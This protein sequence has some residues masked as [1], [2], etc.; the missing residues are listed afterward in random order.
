ME[1]SF[2]KPTIFFFNQKRGGI[3]NRTVYHTK[4]K[5]KI[6]EFTNAKVKPISLYLQS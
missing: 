1:D 2:N 3:Y 6:T 5:I 4:F